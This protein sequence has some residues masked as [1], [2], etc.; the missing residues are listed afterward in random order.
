MCLSHDIE[1]VCYLMCSRQYNLDYTD[2][3][4]L[5]RFLSMR[6]IYPTLPWFWQVQRGVVAGHQPLQ[7]GHA[8]E[9]VVKTLSPLTQQK[10][11]VTSPSFN[12][13]AD[14]PYEYTQY[15]GNIFPGLAWTEG[16]AGTRSYAVIGRPRTMARDRLFLDA[17]ADQGP[18]RARHGSEIL[19]VFK[20]LYLKDQPWTDEDRKIADT[21][22]SYWANFVTVGIP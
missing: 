9:L 13:G 8:T 1:T 4:H 7:M 15:R 20:N 10:L 11:T 21:R 19:F 12:E 3:Y 16:P 5:R 2:A 6:N 17:P 22:S 14:I 18:R